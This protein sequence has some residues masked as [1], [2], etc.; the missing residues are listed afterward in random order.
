M[1]HGAWGFVLSIINA[2]VFMFDAYNVFY[3]LG[4]KKFMMTNKATLRCCVTSKHLAHVSPM[5]L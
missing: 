4:H 3:F 2:I 1:I 5:L